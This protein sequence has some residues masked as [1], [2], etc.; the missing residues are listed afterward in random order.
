MPEYSKL[1]V[2]DLKAELKKRGLPQSGLK[3]V[4]I[5]RLIES[6]RVSEDQPAEEPSTGSEF[7]HQED[8]KNFALETETASKDETHDVTA[9]KTTK[10]THDPNEDAQNGRVNEA[11]VVDQKESPAKG[12]DDG[13]LTGVDMNNE[14][15]T[16]NDTTLMEEK[17]YPFEPRDVLEPKILEVSADPA[18]AL[19]LRTEEKEDPLHNAIE[20]MGETVEEKPKV[21]PEVLTDVSLNVSDDK[22]TE[23]AIDESKKRK[24]RSETPPVTEEVAQK[25]AKQNDGSPRVVLPE[26]ESQKEQSRHDS[27]EAMDIDQEATKSEKL[28]IS[29]TSNSTA[30]KAAPETTATTMDQSSDAQTPQKPSRVASEKGSDK[31]KNETVLSEETKL[32]PSARASASK[33]PASD[34]RFKKLFSTPNTEANRDKPSLQ[35]TTAY[36]NEDRAITPALHPAT[37]ALYIR[38]F[39]RPLQPRNLKD[40]LSAL[41]TPPGSSP[42]PEIITDFFLDTIRTHCF[43]GFKTISA[44]SRVRSYMHDR[45]WPD[46]RTRKPLWVDFVPEDKVKEWIETEQSDSSGGRHSV[47][48]RWE[49]IYEEGPDGMTAVLQEVGMGGRLGTKNPP[50]NNRNIIADSRESLGDN[51]QRRF[52]ATATQPRL[53]DSFKALDELFRFTT[54]KPKL[55]YLPV[56]TQLAE[57]RLD[58]LYAVHRDSRPSSRRGDGEMRRYTFEDG[59]LFVDNGR[60]FGYSQRGGRGRARGRGYGGE[61]WRGSHGRDYGYGGR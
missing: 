1:K 6:D 14:P 22:E 19:T 3:Q 16:P 31:S 47:G 56:S 58:K 57:Q 24:R 27:A 15:T 18:P 53:P 32:S 41:A 4:L 40:H 36:E 54:A 7:D 5:D 37:C 52:S 59:D 50:P 44:A 34:A 43:V 29:L 25:K 38:D 17:R 30:D 10:E 11:Q 55:Y 21:P 12:P 61:S 13:E 26:D 23:E 51:S 49:V 20:T 45:V 48:K 28:P 42:K 39:M 60:D 9:E 35:Q 33:P 2:V 8:A 46:E